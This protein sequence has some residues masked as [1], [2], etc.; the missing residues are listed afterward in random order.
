[1]KSVLVIS[2]VTFA[3][4]FGAIVML[5]GIIPKSTVVVPPSPGFTPED[6]AAAERAFADLAAERD[7]I[8]RE[9]EGL[10]AR[11]Q[12]VAAETVLLTA[13]QE[14]MQALL[15]TLRVSRRDFAAER[16]AAVVKLAKMYEAMKPEKAAPILAS[17]EMDVILDVLSRMKERPAARILAS[18]NSELAATISA[19]LSARG[20]G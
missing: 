19:R 5:S 4:I 20:I 12:S 9:R 11:Q 8:Q 18:M 2:A 3:L 16:E 15:D 7:R 10:L 1:M 6:V 14:K 13:Q 17:L